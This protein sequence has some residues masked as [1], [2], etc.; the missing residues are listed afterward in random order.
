M[1]VYI[2][3]YKGW[4]GPYQIAE[5]ILFW[6]DK[7]DD[8]VDRFGQ[9]LASNKNGDESYL[10]KFCLWLEKKNKRKIKVR[11]D[12]Y[13]TWGMD[14][15]LSYIVL[16]MLKQLKATKHGSPFV[17]KEDLPPELQMTERETYYM[18]YGVLDENKTEA[19][20]EE[21]EAINKKFFSGWDWVMDQMI[22]SFEQNMDDEEGRKHYYDPYL[23][24]EEVERFK[25]HII[26][27]DGNVTEEPEPLFSDE[28]CRRMGKFNVEKHKAY[29]ARKQL[30]FT[31]F[32][33]YFQALWD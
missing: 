31:L 8:R 2:G 10:T 32:G 17:D 29:A 30:G 4:V 14:S 7:D 6:M 11:I 12:P 33:K 5:K 19:T 25:S 22:W 26:D 18:N 15:T 23:P 3:P 28:L 16:P 20:E 13:D 1:K 27:E 21:A 24:G 9:W